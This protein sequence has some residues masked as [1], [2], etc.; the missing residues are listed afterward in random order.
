[1]QLACVSVSF[2]NAIFS[3]IAN[4]N[5]LSWTWSTEQIIR[6]RKG[7]RVIQEFQIAD[8]VL[9]AIG[10]PTSRSKSEDWRYETI[11]IGSSSF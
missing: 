1:M 5:E 3:E 10:G 11:P 9:L 4:S 7:G 6:R 8:P 2:N